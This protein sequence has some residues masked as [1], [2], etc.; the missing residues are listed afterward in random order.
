MTI[1][2]DTI[3]DLQNKIEAETGLR[4]VQVSSRQQL[5]EL[6]TGGLADL[7]KDVF[8]GEPYNEKFELDEVKDIFREFL[9]K[10][11]IIFVAL[12]PAAN[13]RP[14]AFVTSV[15]LK[16]EF[17]IAAMVENCDNINIDAAGYFAEDGVAEDYRRRGISGRMKKLLLEANSI[18]GLRQVL[19][20]TS[21]KN[22]V[23]IN[24]VNKAGGRVLTPL[25]QKIARN[26]N[27]GG[28][29]IDNNLFFLF[30]R[31][32][33]R[34]PRV[35]DRVIVMRTE[36]GD[37]KAF[38]FDKRKLR[39]IGLRG[40]IKKTYPRIKSVRYVLSLQELPEGRVLFDGRMYAGQAERLTCEADA[41]APMC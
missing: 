19:L 22:Y 24:A 1:Q 39:D 27:D 9:E 17:E 23:Q 7:Y 13:D 36:A 34:E 28:T 2:T 40:K 4:A 25:F 12:D 35:L 6:L 41:L 5:E 3:T 15:P 26:T 31:N 29:E 37:D 20:R 21:T 14:V 38:V 32:D 30:N 11:G 16:A 33:M 8:A 10:K 18:A